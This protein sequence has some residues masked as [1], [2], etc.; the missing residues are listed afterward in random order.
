MFV[1]IAFQ[2][3][4]QKDHEFGLH[5]EFQARVCYNRKTP[6]KTRKQASKQNQNSTERERERKKEQKKG[7]TKEGRREEKTMETL[8]N[9]SSGPGC[10]VLGVQ[11]V[12]T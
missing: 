2:G 12:M 9:H 3:Q 8:L 10:S 11:A 1:V 6:L 7:R 5:T 4:R